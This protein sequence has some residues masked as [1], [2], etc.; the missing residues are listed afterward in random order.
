MDETITYVGLDAHKKTISV[1]VAE[2]GRD[3][4]VRA[5]GS[6]AN[7][8][9]TVA[10]L[11]KK[12][13]AAHRKLR[14]CYEAGPCG[15]GL[16]RQLTA[17]GHDCVVA[18]P[19]L[20][21]RRPGERV[22]TDRRDSLTL[23]RSDRAGELTLVWVPDP[24][25]EAMR[26]LVRGREQ[27]VAELRRHRQHL[28]ALLLRHGRI[29]LGE[30]SWTRAHLAWITGLTWQHPAHRILVEDHLAAITAARGRRD[31]LT[32]AIAALLPDW[33]WAPVVSALQ[34]MRGIALISAV[35]LVAA[36]GDISRFRAQAPARRHH[37]GRQQQRTAR[38]HRGRLDLS[39]SA[40][41]EP[42]DAGAPDW[43]AQGGARDCREGA[44]APVRPLPNAGG[45]G[46]TQCGHRHRD[47][48]RD[49]RLHLGNRPRGATGAA[50]ADRC[51]QPEQEV[52]A[53]LPSIHCASPAAGRGWGTLGSCNVAFDARPQ[54]EAA[55][56]RKHG[57]AVPNPRI[58]ACATDVSRAL[59]PAMRND[60][61][62]AHRARGR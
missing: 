16:Y 33:H 24:A 12:L 9:A 46:Q 56:R 8:P 6:I 1:A 47:C 42:G 50:I 57:P 17:L 19:S 31:R 15:Y 41:A 61:S 23:A 39:Q 48:A 25:H 38:A 44:A 53:D 26:D 29:W 28:Q 4:V 43:A 22:K 27:A 34:A 18:A 37:Q 58:R 7:Q 14:F 54:S 30:T 11:A 52:L 3:G 36:I 59:P 62:I 45:A 35:S 10:R 20:I 60:I 32:D 2:S 5:L 51:G 49:G 55:P 21:P 13:A 40:A